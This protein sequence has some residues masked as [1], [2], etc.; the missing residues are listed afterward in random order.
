[1]MQP[2]MWSLSL[3]AQQTWFHGQAVP[4]SPMFLS[5]Q[6]G[7]EPLPAPALAMDYWVIFH[8]HNLKDSSISQGGECWWDK[9]IRLHHKKVGKICGKLDPN[10]LLQLSL[11]T[12]CRRGKGKDQE[13]RKGKM[14]KVRAGTE[15]V[16]TCAVGVVQGCSCQLESSLSS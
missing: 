14:R 10:T 12:G 16:R 1:M 13:R 15:Q 7:L 3:W 2:Q 9:Q 4:T 11:E 6:A 5:T 8:S